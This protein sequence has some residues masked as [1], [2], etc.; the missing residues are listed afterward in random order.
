[1]FRV[2]GAVT[3]I[4]K[5]NWDYNTF[6]NN[7][8]NSFTYRNFYLSSSDPTYNEFVNDLEGLDTRDTLSPFETDMPTK[9]RAGIMFQPNSK[10]LIEF[11]WVKGEN[12]LPGNSTNSIFSLGG[13][14]YVLKFLPVRAGVSAGGPDEWTVSLGAGLKLKNV[15][16]D[17]AAYGINN[18]IAD[19]RLS[20]AFS[21]KLA[22]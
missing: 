4:G 8:T 7:D 15:V 10:F 5:I 18:M 19:K 9:Y 14:Y 6:V 22:L 13:E 20:F 16:L 1:M 11:D 2:A 3:D 17:F 12:N 21:G